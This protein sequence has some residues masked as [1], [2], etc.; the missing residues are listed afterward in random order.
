[1]TKTGVSVSLV[2]NVGVFS[3]E[4]VEDDGRLLRCSTATFRKLEA[5]GL[6]EWK[7]CAVRMTH[8]G[9][10]ALAVLP[11]PSTHKIGYAHG[12]TGNYDADGVFRA[13][14]GPMIF[15]AWCSCENFRY[16]GD[17]DGRRIA[18][19]NHRHNS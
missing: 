14:G 19:S 8:A 9:W 11:L 15:S 18:V 3:L 5:L 16:D 4:S 2:S 1:M 12:S 6:A 17:E 13:F 7:A 10:N